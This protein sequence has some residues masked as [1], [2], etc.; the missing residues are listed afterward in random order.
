MIPIL[1][2]KPATDELNA[3]LAAHR[4]VHTERQ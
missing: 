1:D 2:S 3:F 4:V